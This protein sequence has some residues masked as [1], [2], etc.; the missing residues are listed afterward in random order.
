MESLQ[1]AIHLLDSQWLNLE[2]DWLQCSDN[3]MI[4]TGGDATG[5]GGSL[6]DVRH[7]DAAEL[8]KHRKTSSASNLRRPSI[9]GGCIPDIAIVA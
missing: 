6:Q 1:A 9:S 4:V 7:G 2:V 5:G 8:T 3:V